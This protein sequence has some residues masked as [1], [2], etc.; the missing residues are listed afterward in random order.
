MTQ[1]SPDGLDH[2]GFLRAAKWR[3]DLQ[4]LQET[5]EHPE[6]FLVSL[7]ALDGDV[8][9]F[10]ITCGFR[11]FADGER[12]RDSDF[13]TIHEVGDK[14]FCRSGGASHF[15][16]AGFFGK[17]CEST[18]GK[19]IQ[20]ADALGYFIDCGEELLILSL[21]RC[22]KLEKVWSLHIPMCEVGLSH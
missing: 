21:E 19:G 3:T 1:K 16:D 5:A 20:G 14:I 12:G 13:V 8:L 6:S 4:V 15:R 9:S 17:R 22:M 18:R 10:K 7:D 11:G 2:Q